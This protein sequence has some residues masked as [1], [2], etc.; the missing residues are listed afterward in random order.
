[1]HQ[2]TLQQ[3]ADFHC[4]VHSD[5]IIVF[6]LPQPV[7]LVFLVDFF[8]RVVNEGIGPQRTAGGTL[9]FVKVFIF[10]CCA[11]LLFCFISPFHRVLTIRV[12]NGVYQAVPVGLVSHAATHSCVLLV[13]GSSVD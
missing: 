13:Y 4:G 2:K 5:K 7:G 11:Y 8:S 3:N 6:R 9:T 1:M 12:A 10:F